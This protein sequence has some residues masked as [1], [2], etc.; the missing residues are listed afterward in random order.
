MCMCHPLGV[1]CLVGSPS[2][3]TCPFRRTVVWI[4]VVLIYLFIAG[5]CAGSLAIVTRHDFVEGGCPPVA[6]A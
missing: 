2:H 4:S 6:S 5:H 3:S 1:H